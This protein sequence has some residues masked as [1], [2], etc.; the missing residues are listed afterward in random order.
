MGEG[1]MLRTHIIWMMSIVVAVG[2]VVAA[3]IGATRGV[4]GGDTALPPN[5]VPATGTAATAH[6]AQMVDGQRWSVSIFT[7]ELGEHCINDVPP[8]ASPSEDGG[9][10]N[11]LKP[12]ALF[13]NAPIFWSVG[14]RQQ[15]GQPL[16]WSAVWIYGQAA[17]SIAR[18]TV[19]STTCV[20]HDLPLDEAG[21]FLGVVTRA[22][23]AAGAWPLRIRAYD[24]TGTQVFIRRIPLNPPPTP[25]ARAAGVAAPVPNAACAS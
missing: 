12:D 1:N 8:T 9:A 2:V 22:A 4:S 16:S 5:E 15:P 20:E 24:K 10:L 13:A 19:E 21:V 14:A 18:V 23:L 3:A 6:A 17:T 11:C 25:A 7:N